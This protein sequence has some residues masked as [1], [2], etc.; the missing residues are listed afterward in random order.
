MPDHQRDSKAAVAR[1]LLVV[2]EAHDLMPSP[3]TLERHRKCHRII[4]KHHLS[5]SSGSVDPYC[6]ITVG[7]LTL[8]TAFA[9]RTVKPKWNAPMQFLVY[10]LQDDVIHINVADHEFFS[11][12]G[13]F[14]HSNP[15][16]H[17]LLVFLENL[18]TT[19]VPLVDLLPTP[20]DIFLSQPSL[21]FTKQLYLNNG[22]SVA[23]RCVVQLLS[24]SQ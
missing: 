9:K 17:T 7:P 2:L 11:P 6:E 8:K 19:S 18:G 21:P 10:N 22:S 20:L 1:L 13:T 16:T 23:I 12:N 4:D 14:S 5:L 15:T 24:S 3:T